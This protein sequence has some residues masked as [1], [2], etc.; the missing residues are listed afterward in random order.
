MESSAGCCTRDESRVD[1]ICTAAPKSQQ[2][3]LPNVLTSAACPYYMEVSTSLVLE[4]LL[5]N[6]QRFYIKI[7]QLKYK[8]M[9]ASLAQ[10]PLEKEFIKVDAAP[11]CTF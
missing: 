4:I 9:D 8:I 2:G 1:L 3:I 7:L 10:Y 5:K 6:G 11:V